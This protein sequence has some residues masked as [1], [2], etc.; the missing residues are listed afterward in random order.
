MTQ[1][2][3]KTPAN[4][5]DHRMGPLNAAIII[6]EYGD[7]ECPRSGALAP[8]LEKIFKE[9]A[10]HICLVYRHFPMVNLHANAGMAAVAAEAAGEQG[11]FWE[12]HQALLANQYNQNSE[13]IF[14]LARDIGLDLRQFTNDWERDDLL[15]HVHNNIETGNLNGISATPA[16]FINGVLFTG[17]ISYEEIK[18]EIELILR[19]DQL[20][21]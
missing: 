21:L 10:G 19:D 5:S 12:F 1:T 13:A 4:V 11:K 17:N 8:I 16:I 6:V 9:Y 7:Y 18:D 14:S 3:L 15:E 20:S 2:T